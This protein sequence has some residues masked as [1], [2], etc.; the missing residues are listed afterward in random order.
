MISQYNTPP[1]EHYGVKNLLQFVAKRLVMRGFIVGDPDMGPKYAAEH[2][3]TVQRWIHDGEYK[4][5]MSVTKGMDNAIEGLLGL[6]KG[7]NFGKAVLEV[8]PLKQ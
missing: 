4:P 1:A 3:R 6:F 7:E 8:A 5:R 2:Q